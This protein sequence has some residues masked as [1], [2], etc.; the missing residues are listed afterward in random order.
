MRLRNPNEP[1]LSL[2]IMLTIAVIVVWAI[3]GYLIFHYAGPEPINVARFDGPTISTP[4]AKR[5][6]VSVK[7][8]SVA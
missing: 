5:S 1:K 8:T 4:H 6:G 7:P 2:A 3:S